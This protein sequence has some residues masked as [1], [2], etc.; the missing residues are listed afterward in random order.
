MA[1]MMFVL[2]NTDANLY[3][4]QGGTNEPNATFWDLLFPPKSYTILDPRGGWQFAAWLDSP[5]EKDVWVIFAYGYADE[6]RAL[7]QALGVWN[8]Y[9]PDFTIYP[10]SMIEWFFDFN[11]PVPPT[12]AWTFNRAGTADIF[13]VYNNGVGNV[14]QF[15]GTNWVRNTGVDTRRV[16]IYADLPG[17]SWLFRLQV[18]CGFTFAPGFPISVKIRTYSAPVSAGGL[19]LNVIDCIEFQWTSGA[20]GTPYISSY[21]SPTDYLTFQHC[22]AISIELDNG[23]PNNCSIQDIIVCGFGDYPFT[24]PDAGALC[25]GNISSGFYFSNPC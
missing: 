24:T 6:Y 11:I 13:Q 16:I 12:N 9:L 2:N 20:I 23:S 3:V 4:N 5:T 1:D 22:A 8:W 18:Q 17:N 25:P 14:G 10:S 7:N 21:Q 19:A 15:N